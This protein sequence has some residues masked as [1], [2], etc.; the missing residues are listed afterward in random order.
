MKLK[1]GDNV[2]I[3][4]GKDK[5]KKGKIEKIFIDGRVIIPNTNIFKKHTKA[6]GQK[7]PGGIIESARPLSPAKIALVCPKCNKPTRVGF[8]V[9]GNDKHRI[10]LKCKQVI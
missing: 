7:Q 10:C 1:K 3:T 4:A 9:T 5:G 2:I 6:K 8:Q